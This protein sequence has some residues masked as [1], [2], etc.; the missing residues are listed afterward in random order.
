MSIFNHFLSF[1]FLLNISN[2]SVDVT[3]KANPNLLATQSTPGNFTHNT[4]L[5]DDG[6]FL[7]TTDEVPD[8]PLA[9]YDITDLQNIQQVLAHLNRSDNGENN[10]ESNKKNVVAIP[11][12]VFGFMAT[13]ML[14]S[15]FVLPE[16]L[17]TSLALASQ[18]S[19]AMAMA[20]LGAHTRWQTIKAAGPKPL[21]LALLLFVF[22]ILG[23]FFLTSWLV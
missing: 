22:L 15:V 9:S 17:K 12:F 1:L 5:S 20:A 3:D 7:Y 21:L 13:A 2:T 23:G 8:A 11:W 10:T 4:W 16:V 18:F 14:N 6:Q 19:L